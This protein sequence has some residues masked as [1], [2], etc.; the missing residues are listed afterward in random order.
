MFRTSFESYGQGV[1]FSVGVRESYGLFDNCKMVLPKSFEVK[2]SHLT[3]ILVENFKKK[4]CVKG[5]YRNLNRGLIMMRSKPRKS[6]VLIFDVG[7][8]Q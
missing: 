6:V 2:F 8:C 5:N 7:L 1:F 4:I 3:M